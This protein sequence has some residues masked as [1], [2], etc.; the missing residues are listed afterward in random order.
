M[1]FTPPLLLIS[2]S[3]TSQQ[4]GLGKNILL[5]GSSSGIGYEATKMFLNDGYNL[6]LSTRSEA[7]TE[8]MLRR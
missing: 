7:K 1:L 4:P 6:Y 3:Q 5:T 2:P 8:E